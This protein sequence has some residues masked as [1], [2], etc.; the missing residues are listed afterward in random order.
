MG[1]TSALTEAVREALVALRDPDASTGDVRAKLIELHPELEKQV[2]DGLSSTKV[3]QQREWAR[4]QIGGQRQRAKARSVKRRPSGPPTLERYSMAE[5]FLALCGGQAKHAEE[6]LSFLEKIDP[7][8]LRQ[9]YEGWQ[10]LIASAGNAQKARQVLA[11]MRD[12]GMI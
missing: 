12:T 4:E 11:T 6:V 2:E 10:Q 7:A 9:A 8:E 5:R 1:K 3:Y